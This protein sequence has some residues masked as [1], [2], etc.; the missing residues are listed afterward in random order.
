MKKNPEQT[1]ATRS[2]L[3]D[4]YIE[5]LE[6]NQKPTV[7]AIC[8]KAGYNRCTF[9]RYYPSMEA[10][11]SEIEQELRSQLHQIVLQATQQGVQAD[12]MH[13]LARLYREKGKYLYALLSAG[14]DRMVK[15]TRE[16]MA[17]LIMRYFRIENHPHQEIIAVFVSSAI[18]QTFQYWYRAGRNMD[19]DDLVC[20]IGQ[21]IEHGVANLNPAFVGEKVTENRQIFC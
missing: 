14:N 11:L 20:L 21:L 3:K 17:P 8:K 6:D 9:Y 10:I 18:T 4:T 13:G 12:L 7:D 2:I 16:L 1:A 19:I 15:Q 5:L